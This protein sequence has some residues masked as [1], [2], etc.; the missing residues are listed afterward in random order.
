MIKK[1]KQTKKPLTT[2]KGI[3]PEKVGSFFPVKTVSKIP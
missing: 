1:D 3:I 2:Y